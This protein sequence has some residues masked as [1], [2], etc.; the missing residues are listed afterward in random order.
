MAKLK[1]YLPLILAGGSIPT[2]I[3]LG[4]YFTVRQAAVVILVIS[5]GLIFCA[6][7]L[8]TYANRNADGN[9]WWQDDSASGWRGY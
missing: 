8:W 7:A 2:V 6:M 4:N 1:K 5:L 3:V 9:E